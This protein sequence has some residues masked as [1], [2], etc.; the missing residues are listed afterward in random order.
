MSLILFKKFR[1]E[2]HQSM[3]I[4]QKSSFNEYGFSVYAQ[5]LPEND[6]RAQENS[7]VANTYNEII[8]I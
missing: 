2:Q 1:K 6:D 5:K 8:V 3:L 4:N 7:T